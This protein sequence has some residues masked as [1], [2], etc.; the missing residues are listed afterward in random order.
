ME[1][2]GRAAAGSALEEAAKAFALGLKTDA[3]N[4]NCAQVI[5]RNGSNLFSQMWKGVWP[6][7]PSSKVSATL[8]RSHQRESSDSTHAFHSKSADTPAPKTAT[9]EMY[10]T[11]VKQRPGEHPGG[12]LSPEW[13]QAYQGFQCT[14]AL[15]K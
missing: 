8:V 3:S 1:S 5:R 11:C 4:P 7:S 13:L 9:E 2:M 12:S 15:G 14:R 6:S 10:H